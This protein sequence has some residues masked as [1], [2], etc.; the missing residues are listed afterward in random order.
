MQFPTFVFVLSAVLALSGLESVSA[1]ELLPAAM[2]SPGEHELL[3]TNYQAI[4]EKLE[5]EQGAYGSG[6]SEP[7]LDMGKAYYQAGLRLEALQLFKRSMHISRVNAGL[8][9]LAQ[10]PMLRGIIGIYKDQSNWADVTAAYDRIYAIYTNTYGGNGLEILPVLK[11]IRE[12]HITAYLRQPED[13]FGHLFRADTIARSSIDLVS[14]NFGDNDMRLVAL[15]ESLII[16]Q[17]YLAQQKDD[18]GNPRSGVSFG[19]SPN[20][21]I[22]SRKKLLADRAFSNGKNAYRKI[23]QIMEADPSMT[24]LDNAEVYAELGDWHALFDKRGAAKTLYKEALA[25]LEND[26]DANT[27][28]ETLFG[29]PKLLP[30]FSGMS[31]AS[32]ED[33]PS[34]K[35]RLR[36]TKMGFPRDI[37]FME[38]NSENKNYGM[39]SIRRSIR[40]FRFRPRFIDGEAVS[41]ET[42][43]TIKR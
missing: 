19:H 40:S 32:S 35:V 36:V 12:W 38:E 25:I 41:A 27:L 14:R 15:L 31:T 34:V 21:E 23:M 2:D 28:K 33:D 17:F 16:T 43:L 11:E 8:Y 4:I 42:T 30:A 29:T 26:P 22:N 39:P 37:E 13:G 6:L 18:I 10:E 5:V 24:I 9:S 20:T 7:L 1:D 3:V